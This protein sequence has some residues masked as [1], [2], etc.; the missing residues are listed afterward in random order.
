MSYQRDYDR[1]LR[2]GVVGVG[3]H[4]YRNILPTLHYL[5]VTLVA[6]CDRDE[7]LVRRTAQEYGVPAFTDAARMYAGAD[8]DAV[9]ICVG[10]KQHPA[11]ATQALNAG[12]H[13]W[14]E[15]PPGICAADVE[16]ILDVAGDRTCGVGFKKAYMPATR[17][18]Q[19]L[20]TTP[21]FGGL[22]SM[23]AVYPMTIPRDGAGVLE[24]GEVTNWLLNGCHPLSLMLALGGQVSSV[25]TLRGPGDNAVGSVHLAFASGAVGTFY[26][27]A[28]S[29]NGRQ[30]ERYEFFGN[31]RSVTIEDSVKVTYDRG[32]P[33][34]Y[35][36]QRD[37]TAP[38]LDSGSVVWSAEHRLATLENMS[39]FVQGIFDEL[40]DFCTAALDGRA[41]RICD[42]PFALQ[43]MRVYE[44]ALL[45]AGEPIAVEPIAREA[46][47]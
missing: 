37:F 31:R 15:K 3:S 13:V 1:T 30:I 24:R 35:A 25:Q 36:T 14:I 33:F 2:V 10:P 20:I 27:A 45:S 29:P 40:L 7:S 41:V 18:A 26:F 47:S 16:K 17:K 21:G 43:V 11:L 44:A 32:I 38:G 9:L 5:P 4:A 6:L 34:D 22:R 8:L 28:G 39:L 23:L 19:E 42:L 12:V 46:A